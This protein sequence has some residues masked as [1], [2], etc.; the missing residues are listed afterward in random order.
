M[1][2]GRRADRKAFRNLLSRAFSHRSMVDTCKRFHAG[3]LPQSIIQ[4]VGNIQIDSDLRAVAATFVRLQEARHD[5]DYNLA[6]SF[7]RREVM[8]LL[9]E[10]DRAFAAWKRVRT[11][12]SARLFLMVLPLWKELQR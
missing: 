3:T 2:F 8:L 4:T 11:S 1:M 6:E 12:E 10:L 7:Q 9:Q 5:A